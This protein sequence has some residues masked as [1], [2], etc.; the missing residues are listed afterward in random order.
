M[1]HSGLT[2]PLRR[3]LFRRLGATYA[4]NEIG[5]WMGIIALSVL[6]YD[7]TGSALATTVLFLGM[8]FTPAILAPLLVAGVER[9]P[10]R[11]VLPVLY[12]GEAAA[13]GLLALLASRFS[14]P[15]VF[16]VAAIDGALALASRALTRAVVASLLGPSG[17]LRAGNALLNV[18]FTGGAA[19]GP[20]IAGLVVAG[21]G[22][23]SALLLDAVSFYAVAW[24]LFTAGPL[25]RAESEPG[26]MRERVRV[27]LQYIR[28]KPV[29]RRLLVAQGAAFVFFSAVLPVEVV[30][31]KETLGGG[32]SGYGLMLASWGGGMV[33]GSVLFAVARRASLAYLLL[34]G[35]TAVGAAYLGL[36]VAPTLLLA[37]AASVV[38][39]AG[40]G[41]QWVAAISAVQELTVE[42]MQARVLSVLESVGAA[43]PGL[44]FALGGAIAT[45]ASPRATFLAAGLGVFAI[46]LVAAPLLGSKWAERSKT[47]GSSQLDARN[48]VV[49]ELLPG[50]VPI[51]THL[52]VER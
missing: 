14:L 13:F 51:Q 45:L 47:H 28:G 2:A 11:F 19:L 39:G 43:M 31:A 21:F 50:S 3:P 8:S 6:V 37:C 15:L 1:S 32:D 30:Y 24:I 5:D 29:L 4:I 16:V 40:N 44:G 9:P 38:G 23:Q 12:C 33:L 25:P 52:E 42:E 41:V 10:P 27:G 18:A 46:V 36:A 22:V 34:F 20:A 7:E 48:D 17:E 26:S 35:T 49:L